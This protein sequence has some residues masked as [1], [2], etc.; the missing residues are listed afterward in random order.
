MLTGCFGQ[1]LSQELLALGYPS[2]WGQYQVSQENHAV[3]DTRGRME[4]KWVD[5][6]GGWEG[7]QRDPEGMPFFLK[8]GKGMPTVAYGN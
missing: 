8:D 2:L 5:E 3:S 1:P 4:T 6:K 7:R